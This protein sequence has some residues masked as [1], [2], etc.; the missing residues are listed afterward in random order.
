MSA[1]QKLNDLVECSV[2]VELGEISADEAA[3]LGVRSERTRFVGGFSVIS[4]AERDAPVDPDFK[5]RLLQYRQDR[6]SVRG[7]LAECGVEPKAILPLRAWERICD[8]TGLYRF[9]PIG[10]EVRLDPGKFL[11]EVRRSTEIKMKVFN[12][13]SRLLIVCQCIYVL[14]LP[15]AFGIGT[16]SFFWASVGAI[17]AC[18]FLWFFESGQI[19]ANE[20]GIK[21]RVENST[22][23]KWVAKHQ[24]NGTICTQLW[25]NF[26]ESEN[27]P[28]IR[29]SFP[30][31]PADVAARVLAAERTGLTL[32]VALVREAITFKE[33]V[34]AVLLSYRDY[35]MEV[36]RLEA[37]NRDPIIYVTVGS[38]VA[39]VDQFGEFPIEKGVMNE[40]ISSDHLA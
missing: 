9:S 35:L 24:E 32:Q 17:V 7:K 39:I 33:S 8:R 23:R 28:T 4:N 15:F 12:F 40:V 37:L 6:D 38:A 34:S 3:G 27:G 22:V 2:A 26:R 21:R 31:M 25:P 16:A 36:A 20:Q 19:E 29:I 30:D 5:N 10:D 11:Q 13:L 14:S 1:F 18:L